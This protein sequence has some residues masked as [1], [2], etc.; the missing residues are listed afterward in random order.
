MK[1][2]FNVLFVFFVGFLLVSCSDFTIKPKV[3]VEEII[4]TSVKSTI[5]VN[6]ELSLEVSVYPEEVNIYKLEFT[7]SDDNIVSVNSMGVVKGLSVGSATI[8]ANISSVKASILITVSDDILEIVEKPVENLNIGDIYQLKANK[9]VTWSSNDSKIVSVN[10][11]GLVKAHSAGSV[12]I[13][14]TDN[15]VSI[16]ITITVNENILLITPINKLYEGMLP[17]VGNSEL[18]VLMIQFSNDK[19]NSNDSNERIGNL[20][21]ADDLE[22][23][24]V[25][26]FYSESSFDNLELTGDVLPIY[27]AKYYSSYYEREYGDWAS[28][29]LIQEALLYYDNTVD[30]SEF[31]SNDDGIIDNIVA[32]YAKDYDYESDVWWAYNTNYEDPVEDD[33]PQLKLD[34]VFVNNYVWTSIEFLYDDDYLGN[35]IFTIV[36]ELG[37]SFGLDDYYDYD[38]DIGPKGGLGGADLMDDTIGDHNAFSK[39]LLGWVDPIIIDLS[40]VSEHEYSVDSF[41]ESGEFILITNDSSKGIFSEYIIIEYYTPTSLNESNYYFNSSGARLFHVDATLGT[42]D[43]GYYSKFKYDNSDTSKKIIKLIEADG[44]NEIENG[45]TI[46]QRIASDSDLF[47]NDT[48]YILDI[49]KNFRVNFK[50]VNNKLEVILNKIN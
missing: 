20:F 48:S 2:I 32:L 7:S 49:N 43:F 8:T 16:S 38:E 9:E 12:V 46:D 18:L 14:A 31:D 10:E 39:Y 42:N 26:S 29:A 21:F 36:H 24:S 22:Y 28:D 25:K 33:V 45:R 27:T 11:T 47:T 1:K 23:H 50:I 5:L 6:E 35:N 13:T 15:D 41:V 3:E 4:I 37:H 30:Y 34:N 40:R 17:S 44:R 19:F